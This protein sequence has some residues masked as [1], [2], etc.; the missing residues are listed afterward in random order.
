[1]FISLFI[2]MLGLNCYV[3]CNYISTQTPADT[4]YEYMY[5]Y[6]Y[7]DKNVPDGG[8]AGYAKTFKKEVKGYNLILH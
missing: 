4:K 8:Q 2:L 6:K 1:M 3:Q 7:P 5:M